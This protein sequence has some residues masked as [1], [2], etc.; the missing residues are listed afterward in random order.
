MKTTKQLLASS[1]LILFIM[2]TGLFA[3][4]ASNIQGPKAD[5][6]KFYTKSDEPASQYVPDNKP[7]ERMTDEYGESSR[8]SVLSGLNAAGNYV[9]V[10]SNVSFDENFDGSF[11]MWIN[12]VN[13]TGTQQL[14]SKGAT[15]NFAFLLGLNPGGLMY[16]RIGST[17]F[18]NAGGTAIPIG[19]WTHVAVTWTGGPNFTVNFYVNGAASGA[20]VGPTAAT[21]NINTDPIKIGGPSGGFPGEFFNGQIDEVRFWADV[22]TLA[23]IRDNRFVGVGDWL[24]ANTGGTLNGASSYYQDL[25]ASWVFNTGAWDDIGSFDGTLTGAATVANAPLPGQPIPY[26]FA[27]KCPG[28]GNNTSLVTVP[29]NAGLLLNTSGSVDAWVFL[30]STAG[31]QEILAKG[32]TSNNQILW[33]VSSGLMYMR[34][35]TTPAGNTGGITLAANTW[36]HVATTW[37]GTAGNYSVRFYVNGQLSGTA[38]T[39]SGTMNASTDP[40]TIGGGVAFPTETFNGMIDEVRFWST[41]LTLEQVQAYMHRSCRNTGAI[42]GGMVAAWNFDGNLINRGSLA[43]IN[44]SFV[45]GGANA[46][47]FSAYLNENTSGAP[48]LNFNGYGTV[49]NKGDASFIGG[50]AMRSPNKVIADN[51]AVTRDTIVLST[52]GTV[53]SVELFLHLQHTFDGDLDIVL[54]APNGQT[55]DISSDNGSGNDGGYLTFFVDGATTPVT[56]PNFFPP[57]SPLCAPEV[58]MGNMGGSPTNGQWILQITDD[59]GGDVGVLLGWG[60]RLNGTLT[61]IQPITNNVPNRF[62]LYQNYPNPFN[63]VTKIKFDLPKDGNVKLTVYDMLGK[64]V[65]TLV[66][67]FSKAGQYEVPFDGSNLSSG[68]YFFRLE[69]G[70]NVDVKKMMLVK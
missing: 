44:G 24:G 3:Q 43:G 41:Q 45:T 17:V 62:E 7:R 31:T 57:F 30:N 33:G 49:V 16:F 15:S 61:G 68:A 63:P 35:G 48:S 39:N 2:A 29:H 70:D 23:E 47:R 27:L 32:N 13:V 4:D 59:A 10:P 1:I 65:K 51:P 36:Y 28:T 37:T 54:V 52:A 18:S 14:I 55:R 9:S 22:R 53:T 5:Q 11:E 8:N 38:V 56:D 12:P 46:C 42:P 69:A 40:L 20:A 64:E 60:I 21:W 50:F 26:N 6:P 34:F 67:E 25:K 66:N 19:V 58:A